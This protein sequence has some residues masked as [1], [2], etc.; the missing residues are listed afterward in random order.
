MRNFLR[1]WL[2]LDLFI[3]SFRLILRHIECFAT[4]PQIHRVCLAHL[5]GFGRCLVIVVVRPY[6]SAFS[7]HITLHDVRWVARNP[8]RCHHIVIVLSFFGRFSPILLLLLR[9]TLLY[10]LNAWCR[11]SHNLWDLFLHLHDC[12]HHR[13][14]SRSS[15]FLVLS[16]TLLHNI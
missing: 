15:L 16:Q 3:H 13:Q 12:V 9:A 8:R 14:F 10:L 11:D 4:L 1:R 7:L 5:W 6:S 2:Y